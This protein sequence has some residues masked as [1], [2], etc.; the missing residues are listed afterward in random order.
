MAEQLPWFPFYVSK[1]MTDD[2]VLELTG[3]QMAAYLWLLCLQWQHGSLPYEAHRLIPMV[4]RNV[5]DT[6]VVFACLKFFPPDPDT[7]ER[8]NPFLAAVREKQMET[9]RV[10]VSNIAAGRKS[11]QNKEV[12]SYDASYE[13]KKEKEIKKEKDVDEDVL[14]AASFYLR[15]TTTRIPRIGTLRGLLQGISGPP[16]PR[17]ALIRGLEDMT[18]AGAKFTALSVRGFARKAVQ[19]LEGEAGARAAQSSVLGQSDANQSPSGWAED[20]VES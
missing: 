10:R 4:P 20:E 9:Y 16:I 14:R 15:D 2:R 17:A 3:D 8:R 6:A 7:N 5:P 12:S 19:V 13:D 1:W 18:V 11:K